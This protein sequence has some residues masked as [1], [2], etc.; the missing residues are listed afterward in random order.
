MGRPKSLA[1]SRAIPSSASCKRAQNSGH[2]P[3]AD[4]NNYYDFRAR[5][6]RIRKPPRRKSTVTFENPAVVN[7]A[8]IDA[9]VTGTNVLRMCPARC[10]HSRNLRKRPVLQIAGTQMMEH[11]DR[12]RRRKCAVRKRQ[13]R[14][15]PLNYGH[16]RAADA[17]TELHR[18]CVV[19]LKTRHASRKP[20]QLLRGGSRPRA[21][22]QQVLTQLRTLQN[23][24]QKLPPRYIPPERRPTKPR[25]ESIH[26]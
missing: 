2:C 15:I 14:S 17:G 22:L 25:F 10:K 1:S 6:A 8:N 23:P 26:R 5:S 9:G 12:N 4:R 18:K 20:S 11:Q 7:L 13:C 24:R 3:Q 21:Q 19:V 16:P